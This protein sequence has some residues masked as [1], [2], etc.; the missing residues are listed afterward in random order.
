MDGVKFQRYDTK[1]KS[2]EQLI[3]IMALKDEI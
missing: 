3:G 2:A 1:V